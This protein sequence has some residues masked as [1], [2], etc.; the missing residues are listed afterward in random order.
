V[1]LPSYTAGSLPGRHGRRGHGLLPRFSGIDPNDSASRRPASVLRCRKL[2]PAWMAEEIPN[3]FYEIGRRSRARSQRKTE[4]KR[5]ASQP[6]IEMIVTPACNCCITVHATPGRLIYVDGRRP[7]CSYYETIIPFS[8]EIMQPDI[9][10][11]V[12]AALT[13]VQGFPDNRYNF[14]DITPLLESHPKLFHEV[15]KELI[16]RAWHWSY[17]TVLCVESFGYIFG[18]PLAYERGCKIVLMRRPGKLPRPTMK[19]SYQMCYDPARSMEIH[20]GALSP[21]S[22]VLIVDDFLISGGTIGAAVELVRKAGAEVAGI[23]CVVENPTWK[24]RAALEN[25]GVPIVSLATI[26]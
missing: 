16:R 3:V 22:R 25:Y 19:Q 9:E 5:K 2:P 11:R 24:G 26:S 14:P 20:I 10:E 12:R 15:I 4:V 21:S 6:R 8:N 18:V 23:A 17:D 1:P 7:N 13:Y